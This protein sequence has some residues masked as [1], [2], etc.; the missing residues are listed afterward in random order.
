MD[1]SCTD[2]R[3]HHSSRAGSTAVIHTMGQIRQIHCL[4]VVT[5]SPSCLSWSLLEATPSSTIDRDLGNAAA[6]QFLGLVLRVRVLVLELVLRVRVPVL[7]LVLG[8]FITYLAR[9][10]ILERPGK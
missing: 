5:V 6:V 9:R 10:I 4:R 3:D 7:E 8:W 1:E 2:C